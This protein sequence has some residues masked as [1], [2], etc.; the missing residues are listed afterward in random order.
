MNALKIKE[1]CDSNITPMAWQRIVMKNL[2]LFKAKG[3][4]LTE[5]NSPNAS[6]VLDSAM[7]EAIKSSI[8][9]MYQME[10]PDGVLV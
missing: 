1:W 2:D 5:A 9:E 3:W 6:M 8:R 4:G 10:L 7:V